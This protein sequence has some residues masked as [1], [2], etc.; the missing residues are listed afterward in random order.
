MSALPDEEP[1]AADTAANAAAPAAPNEADAE[2][3]VRNLYAIPR[4]AP[5]PDTTDDTSWWARLLEH[6]PRLWTEDT[7]S[8]AS[9]LNRA[10]HGRHLQAT[11]AT[12]SA[13]I[14][15]AIVAGGW[16]TKDKAKI[17]L[18]AHPA[19]IAVALLLLGLLLVSPARPLVAWVLFGWGH[20]MFEAFTG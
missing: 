11:G 16:N 6:T 3:E 13:A 2:A 18:R 10:R 7:P 12:R 4:P 17:W 9:E 19:R 1:V 20:V 8:P 5:E 14:G 15:Y